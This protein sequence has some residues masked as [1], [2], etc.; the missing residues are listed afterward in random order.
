MKKEEKRRE[1][2]DE[3]MRGMILKTGDGHGMGW[4]RGC[5][6]CNWLNSWCLSLQDSRAQDKGPDTRHQTRHQ[7]GLEMD[8]TDA[9]GVIYP[10]F[11]VRG[12]TVVNQF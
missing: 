3:E 5:S 4:G 12:A 1:E 8:W 6:S 7:K 9:D 10:A 11:S 2:G